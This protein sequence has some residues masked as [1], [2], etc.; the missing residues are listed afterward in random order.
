MGLLCAALVASAC[1]SPSDLARRDPAALVVVNGNGQ[2]GAAGQLLAGP[3]IVKVTDD[4]GRAVPGQAVTFQV[5]SGGGSVLSGT[6]TTD[7]DGIAR[8]RWRL[9]TGGAQALE[10]RVAIGS[11]ATVTAA[12]TAILIGAAPASFQHQAP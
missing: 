3:L 11:G 10:A 8:E 12:F 9:G 2:Q 1:G 6:V 4:R 5:T 7:A